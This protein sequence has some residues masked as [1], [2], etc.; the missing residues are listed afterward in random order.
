MWR[1]GIRAAGIALAVVVVLAFSGCGGHKAAVQSPPKAPQS[2]DTKGARVVHY[3]LDGRD[4]IAV[5]PRKTSRRLLVFLHGRGAGPE[6]F[7]SNQLF[8]ALAQPGSPV[9]VMLNGGD[10]SYWHNRRSGKW[11]SMVLNRAI[12]DARRRFHTKGKVALGGI[13]MGGYGALHIASLRPSEF[14]AAG[15]HSAALWRRAGATAPGA[16]DNA[17]DYKRN[18]VFTAVKKLK[19]V[20]VW[21]DVGDQDSFRAADAELARR[22]SVILHVYPGGH[23]SA[24]WNGHMA[25]YLAFYRLA[26]G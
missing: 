13:S 9:V 8:A 3:T 23:D 4:E 5:V 15:G 16:F 17:E 14:C 10:H 20:K 1:Y 26:C 21:L 2:S 18:N 24:Y 25:V 6:Q 11:A 12:P 19:K 22:L 7:L